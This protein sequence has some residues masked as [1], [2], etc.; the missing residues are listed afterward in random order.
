MPG[1]RLILVALLAAGGQNINAIM[2]RAAED[3]RAGRFSVAVRGFDRAALL[4][5]AEAPF[6]WQR[7]IA[8]YYA[9]QFRECARMF[10]SHRTVNPDDV[11]NAAWH[12]LCVARSESPEAARRQLLPVGPDSRAPMREIYQMYQGRA[13]PAAVLKAAGTGVRAQFYARL[14]SGL[15][16]EATGLRDAGRAQI[17][18]AAEPRYA[19][20][21]GYMHAVA[22]V[23]LLAGEK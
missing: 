4:A 20:A 14:Y 18:I 12:F 9:G 22:R 10:A 3:F 19:D 23:H 2:E 6:M 5:P 8:Q 13:T 7:G 17:E 16:L 1:V 21:G 15:Y 11:E